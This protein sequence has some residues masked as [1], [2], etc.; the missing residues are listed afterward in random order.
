MET[1]KRLLV[2]FKSKVAVLVATL[3]VSVFIVFVIEYFRNIPEVQLLAKSVSPNGQLEARVVR[4]ISSPLMG[5]AIVWQ[6][7]QIARSGTRLKFIQS[8]QNM[9][10]VISIQDDSETPAANIGWYS[11]SELIIESNRIGSKEILVKPVLG[12]NIIYR[13]LPR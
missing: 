9:G 7:V 12:V 4:I 1:K 10:F 2:I 5:G 13:L 6:E 3:L 8:E 11:Q